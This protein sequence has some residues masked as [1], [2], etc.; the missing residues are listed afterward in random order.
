[1]SFPVDEFFADEIAIAATWTPG[2][3]VAASSIKVVQERGD[4][5]NTI[6][7]IEFANVGIKVFARTSDVSTA[8]PGTSTITIG[9]IVYNIKSTF[10]DGE[11]ITTLFLSRD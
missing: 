11:G 10:D 1:M 7:G 8:T 2:G 4:L 5:V 9:T 3:G 6:V